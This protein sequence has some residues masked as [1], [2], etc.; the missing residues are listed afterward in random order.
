MGKRIV[1]PLVGVIISAT[2]AAG[3]LTAGG[4]ASAMTDASSARHFAAASAARTADDPAD[5]RRHWVRDQLRWAGHHGYTVTALEP[6]SLSDR[7]GTRRTPL[8]G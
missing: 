2:A 3:I 8:G 1:R 7:R 6:H 5:V 4:P